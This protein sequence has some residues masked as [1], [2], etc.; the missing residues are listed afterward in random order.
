[1]ISKS[2]FARLTK[3]YQNPA[4]LTSIYGVYIK[5]QSI[6]RIRH[7]KRIKNFILKNPCKINIYV[8]LQN[9]KNAGNPASKN[10]SFWT[11]NEECIDISGHA[12]A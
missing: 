1:M 6:C 10:S 4:S 12:R 5:T 2:W 3:I 11:L 9:C 8:N 7:C